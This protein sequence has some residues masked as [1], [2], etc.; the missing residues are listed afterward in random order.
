LRVIPGHPDGARGLK[1]LGDFDLFESL[2]VS[3]PAVFL[4]AWV[5]LF[6]LGGP[7]P[8]W[9]AYRIYLHPYLVLLAGLPLWPDG[10]DHIGCGRLQPS[11]GKGRSPAARPP[12]VTL[13]Q[14]RAAWLVAPEALTTILA[15]V[16]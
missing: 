9:S 13:V 8:L 10:E 3:L 2:T 11:R 12:A 7:S 4:S 16:A 15:V 1:L 14:Q 6:S 5:L